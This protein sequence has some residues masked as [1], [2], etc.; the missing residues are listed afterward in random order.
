MTSTEDLPPLSC[1]GG[2]GLTLKK[3]SYFQNLGSLL[4]WHLYAKYSNKLAPLKK[5]RNYKIWQQIVE[6]LDKINLYSLTLKTHFITKSNRI[7]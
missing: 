2:T 3:S 1:V 4:K 7:S 5:K 6:T